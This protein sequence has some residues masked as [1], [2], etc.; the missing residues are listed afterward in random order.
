[1][2]YDALHDQSVDGADAHFLFNTLRMQLTKNVCESFHSHLSKYHYHPHLYTSLFVMNLKEYQNLI[3]VKLR[4]VNL[5]DTVTNKE[6]RLLRDWQMIQLKYMEKD[7]FLSW[8]LFPKLITDIKKND[9]CYRDGQIVVKQTIK[10]LNVVSVLTKFHKRRL[11]C[12]INK[13][14]NVFFP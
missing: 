1:M 8:N 6:V 14:D 3:Y 5:S 4:S 10:L 11:H 13:R 12:L 2:F 9:V 7:K